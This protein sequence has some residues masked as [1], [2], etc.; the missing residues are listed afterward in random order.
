MRIKGK[1]I[2]RAGIG[3]GLILAFV[4]VFDGEAS[5]YGTITYRERISLTPGATLTVQL[6]DASYMDAPAQLIAEQVISDPGQVPIKFKVPYHR[7]DIDPGSTYSISAR[8][9]ESDGRL[10]FIN[11]TAY[12]VITR[13]NPGKVNIVLAMVEPPPHMVDGEWSAADRAP[14]EEAVSVTDVH[15]IWQGDEAFVRVV[16]LVSDIDGCYQRGREEATVDG[17]VV[18]VAVTAWVPPPAPWAI[19]CS[20]KNLELD[21]IVS[22]GNSLVTGETY[23]V[24]VNGE[25]SLTFTVP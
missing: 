24:T 11:D 9:D 25:Y 7:G 6:R 21:G 17:L 15:M 20:D 22:L 14:V 10:A 4:A 18:D 12:D 5:V 16:Y 2:L 19:D 1:T 23:S 13:G 3:I 8:I